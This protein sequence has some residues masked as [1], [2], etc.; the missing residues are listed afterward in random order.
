MIL[1]EIQVYCMFKS[2]LAYDVSIPVLKPIHSA[3]TQRS[4]HKDTKQQII[5][6]VFVFISD[7]EYTRNSSDLETLVW[8]PET[9]LSNKQIDQFLVIAR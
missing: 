1:C 6:N 5:N 7:E 9:G 3:F 8:S 4:I 2:V